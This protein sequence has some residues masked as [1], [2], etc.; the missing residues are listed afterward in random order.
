[1][2]RDGA[3]LVARLGGTYLP[4]SS[5]LPAPMVRAAPTHDSRRV[6]PGGVFVAIPGRR[7]DGARFAAEAIERGAVLCVAERDLGVSV[8]MVVVA[9][10]RRA[11]ATE[12]GRAHV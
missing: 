5:A 10:A 8:P 12:I 4:G 6:E 3:A 1:M 2:Q 7:Q 11:L 9:D